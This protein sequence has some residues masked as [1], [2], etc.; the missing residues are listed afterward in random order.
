MYMV[1]GYWSVTNVGFSFWGVTGENFVER[2]NWVIS[3]VYIFDF[4]T[5]FRYDVFYI[6]GQLIY[7][8]PKC[9]AMMYVP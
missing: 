6:F 9:N 7:M 8:F 5:T 4:S 2:R 1:C 3:M